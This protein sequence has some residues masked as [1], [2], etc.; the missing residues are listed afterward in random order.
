MSIGDYLLVQPLA[1]DIFYVNKKGSYPYID[2]NMHCMVD[3]KMQTEIWSLQSARFGQLYY[4][5]KG[6]GG[7]DICLSDSPDY[8]LCCT[9]KSARINGVDIWRQTK[10]R[11][12]IVEH[13]SEHENL[14]DKET[15][16]QRINNIQSVPVLSCRENPIT[17]GHV[18]HVKRQLRRT[19]KN[20]SL[21]LH[22]FMDIWN[23]NMPITTAKRIN[24]YTHAHPTENVVEVMRRQGFHFIPIEIRIKYHIDKNIKL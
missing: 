14:E 12:T 9:L 24:L 21:P 4:H 16:I 3:P 23:K 19:D 15:V 8:A 10:V 5:L 2:T 22:S 18:Y 1:V 17:K 13:I 20:S 7:I 11:N 6:A